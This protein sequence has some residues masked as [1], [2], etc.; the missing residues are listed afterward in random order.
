[1]ARLDSWHCSNLDPIQFPN[2]KNF[3]LVPAALFVGKRPVFIFASLV[4][5]ASTIWA[6]EAKRFSSLVGA[7]IVSAIAA[8]AREALTAAI[9]ADIF[10]LHERGWWMGFYLIFLC[11]GISLGG[12]VSGFIINALGWRWHFWVSYSVI[13]LLIEQVTVIFSSAD[14]LAILLFFPETPS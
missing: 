13:S 12:L 7:R 2:L 9:S 10:F 14:A 1:L 11:G 6:A 3:V 5:F 8:T 4:L